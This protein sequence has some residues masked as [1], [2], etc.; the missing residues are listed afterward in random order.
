MMD[1]NAMP[2]MPGPAAAAPTPPPPRVAAPA[3]TGGGA[4]LED[5]A[6]ALAR[7]E[8]ALAAPPLDVHAVSRDGVPALKARFR[9]ERAAALSSRGR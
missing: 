4:T 8:A 7:A 3:A 2:A 5:L 9:C 1:Q 6:A